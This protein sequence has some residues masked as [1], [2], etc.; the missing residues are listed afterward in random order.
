ME[1]NRTEI[2]TGHPSTTRMCSPPPHC[3]LRHPHPRQESAH[4]FFTVQPSFHLLHPIM[5]ICRYYQTPGGCRYGK[6][7]KYE[8]IDPPGGG[9][10]SS[11]APPSHDPFSSP[12]KPQGRHNGHKPSDDTLQWPLSVIALKES[13]DQGNVL[14]GDWSPEELRVQ[15]YQMAPRGMS[16][17]VTQRESQLLAEHQA[18]LDA[19]SR[20][21]MHAADPISSSAFRMKDPFAQDANAPSQPHQTFG[22]FGAVNGGAPPQPFV[23][24]PAQM[25][26]Q[27]MLDSHSPFMAPAQQ[28]ANMFAQN[29]SFGQPP[30]APVQNPAP[31]SD[32]AHDAQFSATQ[33]GFAKVPEAAPPPKFY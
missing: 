29:P 2:K 30:L 32:S 7:C 13:V 17:E 4:F 9:N 23:Q 33:F 15:A 3:E 16:T 10:V 8:H 11:T 24:Q 31:V 20:G 12:T 28:G 19:L 22:A 27:Q 14:D 21:G 1:Q 6:N 25:A 18:K 26:P 5:V